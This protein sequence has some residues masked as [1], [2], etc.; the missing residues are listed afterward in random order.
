MNMRFLQ[1]LAARDPLA[2]MRLARHVPNLVRLYWR[3]LRDPR[4]SRLAKAVLLAGV[5]YFVMPLD[6]IPDFPLVGF[7]WLDDIVVMMIAGQ[8]FIRLCP[9]R[10]V[11]EHVRLIDEGS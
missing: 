2:V 7:G 6:L 10:V 8:F 9:P 3:L 1:D 11:Q 4:V 5:A